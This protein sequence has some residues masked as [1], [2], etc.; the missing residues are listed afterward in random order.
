MHKSEDS[1]VDEL[2]QTYGET[3]GINYLAAA[4][5]LPS[6]LSIENSC[7]DLMSLM[8]PGFRSEPLV[9]SEDRAAITPVRV[10]TLRARLK[11]EICRSLGKIPPNEATETEAEKF[12]TKFFAELPNVRRLLWT[13]IDA[14]FEGD[15]AARS[16][17]EII[18]AYPSLEAIAIQRM[19]HL[20]YLRELPL[21]PRIMTEW[22]RSR[23]GIDMHR[24]AKRGS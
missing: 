1:A 24:G 14:A 3:G 10:R 9:S 5:T 23:T 21:I 12:L 16:Y 6:R 13:D 18:L 17:E 20:L 4:A 2:L 11:T 15:P 7:T 19:A 8:F 22:A